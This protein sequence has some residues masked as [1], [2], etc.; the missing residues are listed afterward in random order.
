VSKKS[1]AE[2]KRIVRKRSLSQ[3]SYLH[4][5]LSYF[6][7]Q[8]GY[9]LDE[10]KILYKQLNPSVYVYRKG[11]HTF[12]RSSADLDTAEMTKTIDKFRDQS[13]EMGFP[14]PAPTD[15]EWLRQIENEVERAGY[16]L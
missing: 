13:K 5:I 8:F 7:S 10:A 15:Q 6:G 14:L 1:L 9:T 4:L 3:N 2:L 12:L 16:Y 11:R